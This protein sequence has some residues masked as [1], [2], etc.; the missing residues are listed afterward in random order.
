MY[1]YTKSTKS[2]RII[3]FQRIQYAKVDSDVISKLKG[4]FTERPK[5]SKEEK[6]KKKAKDAK[7]KYMH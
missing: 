2:K 5:K 3:I 4:T 6:K 1:I 7:V